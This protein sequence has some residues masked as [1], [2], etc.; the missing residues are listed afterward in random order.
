MIS[1]PQ[2]KQLHIDSSI[3]QNCFVKLNELDEHQVI[4]DRIKLDLLNAYNYTHRLNFP[5]VKVKIETLE[6]STELDDQFDDDVE[7]NFIDMGSPESPEIDYV[8]VE[9]IMNKKNLKREFDEIQKPRKKRG[10]RPKYGSREENIITHVINGMTHY[11]CRIC[12]RTVKKRAQIK[13]HIQI[14][15]SERNICCQECGMMCKLNQNFIL[16]ALLKFLFLVKT[17]SCLYSHRKIHME[18]ERMHW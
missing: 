9:R 5:D 3:C 4:A 16:I 2:Q 6:T 1:S 13:Q 15:T 11:Q 14:H 17:Q 12:N 8:E 7:E 10:P 18:R